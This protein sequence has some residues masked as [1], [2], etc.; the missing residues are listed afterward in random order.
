MKSNI[1]L[2]QIIKVEDILYNNIKQIMYHLSKK[3]SYYLRHKLDM[4]NYTKDA[5]V[6]ISEL[7]D[8]KIVPSNIN[9]ED[10]KRMVDSDKKNRFDLKLEVINQKEEYYLRANQ[11][12][13]SGTLD[14]SLMF[15]EIREP[16]DNVFHGTFRDKISI[17]KKTGLNKMNRQ[18]I[19]FACDEK[20]E[21]KRYNSEVKIYLDMK[22]AIE[23]GIKFYYSKNK[24]ILSKGIDGTILPKYFKEITSIT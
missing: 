4:F 13:S 5:Y 24:V 11:G 17:I 1:S 22:K 14:Y 23:D 8:R 18:F 3:L 10:L 15:E 2:S 12:H 9:L 6:K 21:L 7:R 19:H 16:I 20:E